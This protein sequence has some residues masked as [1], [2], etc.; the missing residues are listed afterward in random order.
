M[1]IADER[2]LV[3]RETQVGV[4][5]GGRDPGGAQLEQGVVAVIVAGHKAGIGS[6][7][8]V[9]AVGIAERSDDFLVAIIERDRV[10]LRVLP[11]S[12]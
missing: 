11:P 5:L 4:A 9:G 3:P 8:D 1:D 6:E 12:K 10:I 7:S 2:S